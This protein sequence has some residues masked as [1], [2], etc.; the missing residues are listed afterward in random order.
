MRLLLSKDWGGDKIY[1]GN[2][3]Q[4]FWVLQ[5]IFLLIYSLDVYF[6]LLSS[7]LMSIIYIVHKKIDIRKSTFCSDLGLL[8]IIRRGKNYTRV[9]FRKEPDNEILSI[10]SLATHWW[11]CSVWRKSFPCSYKDPVYLV[12]ITVYML[13]EILRLRYHWHLWRFF[14]AENNIWSMVKTHN[15]F[16]IL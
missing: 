14:Y 6:C 11:Q 3:S 13:I 7:D 9:C 2:V 12:N 5:D 4:N 10:G 15:S 1:C 16:R 8:H